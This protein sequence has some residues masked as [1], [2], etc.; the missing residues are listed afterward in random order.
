MQSSVTDLQ[1]IEADGMPVA[2]LARFAQRAPVCCS[3]DAPVRSALETMRRLTIGSMIVV[4][5]TQAVLGIF[6]LRDVLDR[7]ALEPLALEAP[8]GRFMTA[9]PVTLDRRAS[10]YEAALVMIRHGVRHVIL[11]DGSRVAGVVSERDLFGLQSTGV[12]YLSTGIKGAQSLAEIEAYGRDVGALTRQ[13]VARGAAIGPLTAFISS[14]ID[15]LTGRIVE[16]EFAANDIDPS[17]ICWIVLG[18]EGRSEQTLATDQDNGLIFAAENR[19]GIETQRERLAGISRRINGALDRAGFR[20]CAGNIMAGNPQWCLSLD[21]WR[22]RFTHWIDSGSPEALLH[23]SIFFDLRPLAGNLQLGASL[24]AWLRELAPKNRRFLHQ[25]AANALDS[26]P[27][28]GLFGQLSAGKDGSIDLKLHGARPFVDAARIFGLSC[29]LAETRTEARLRKAGPA[30]GIGSNE[31]E[32]WIAAFYHVQGQRLRR[33]VAC[34]D[35]GIACDN[36]L[37]TLGLHD[38]DRVCLRAAFEQSRNLQ[39]RLALDFGVA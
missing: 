26:R 5:E 35:A 39:K 21:E 13:M 11:I 19:S 37:D 22:T 8:I 24:C 18:S 2:S 16:L 23:G 32:A 27:P 25:M 30:L 34:L 6:T 15:L 28:L 1:Q 14:L 38:Y 4:D 29:G 36:K 12:R 33:Q 7:I 9:P 31:T 3:P 10:A 17:T 20:L